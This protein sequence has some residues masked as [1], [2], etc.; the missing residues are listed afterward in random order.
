MGP[1]WWLDLSTSG[2][3]GTSFPFFKATWLGEVFPSCFSWEHMFFALLCLWCPQDF[4]PFWLTE[5]VCRAVATGKGTDLKTGL[6]TSSSKSLCGGGQAQERTHSPSPPTHPDHH[7]YFL[8]IK[9]T[10]VFRE[11]A[12]LSMVL[13]MSR[14][15]SIYSTFCS[16]YKTLYFPLRRGMIHTGH[17]CS[18][19]ELALWC[20]W[21]VFNSYHTH[22]LAIFIPFS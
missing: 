20:V 18:D 4:T 9:E 14:F 10:K 7:R 15:H 2:T 21:Y 11:G 12:R 1:F 19:S 17:L 8:S 22:E 5:A 13:G 16:L 3:P 6:C